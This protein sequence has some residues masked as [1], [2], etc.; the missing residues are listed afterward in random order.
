MGIVSLREHLGI[1]LTMRPG[2]GGKT[3]IYELDGKTAE[4]PAG[5]SSVEIARAFNAPSEPIRTASKLAPV[6]PI[7]QPQATQ[8]NAMSFTGL[9]SGAIQAK[10]AELKQRVADSQA[11]GLAQVDAAA[12]AA[13]TQVEQAFAGVEAKI[14]KETADALQEFAQTT[15]GGPA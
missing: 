12:T 1:N 15:N 8:N 7:A 10:L 9:Q 5:S 6:S 3:E 11:K 4:V 2:D 13:V 14:Q